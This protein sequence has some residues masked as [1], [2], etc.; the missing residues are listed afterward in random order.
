M[1]ALRDAIEHEEAET[2]AAIEAADELRDYLHG[3]RE[4]ATFLGLKTKSQVTRRKAQ[5]WPIANVPG[6]GLIAQRSALVEHR[7]KTVAEA[8]ARQEREAGR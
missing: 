6:E 1:Q 7:R 8:L 3:W 2:D 5:G 4:I